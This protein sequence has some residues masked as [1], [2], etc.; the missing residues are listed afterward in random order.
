MSPIGAKLT[1]FRLTTL[2][3]RNKQFARCQPKSILRP[4]PRESKQDRWESDDFI[5]H[6]NGDW[7][8]FQF[9][10]NHS[11]S[12]TAIVMDQSSACIVGTM[13][14]AFQIFNYC[15]QFE[16]S[17]VFWKTNPTTFPRFL[18]KFGLHMVRNR[19]SIELERLQTSNFSEPVGYRKIM[20]VWR[21]QRP[22]MR[23]PPTKLSCL[24]S[25]SAGLSL[26]AL[27][28]H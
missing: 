23:S 9:D 21:K 12:Q 8:H 17:S 18:G 27:E 24:C 6:R 15:P 28:S 16:N 19:L 7:H 2:K 26:V 5:S 10:S 1:R 14:N 4:C 3:P 20:G 22:C 11:I 25:G 13:L